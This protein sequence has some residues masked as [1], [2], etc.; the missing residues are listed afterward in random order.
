MVRGV[1]GVLVGVAVVLNSAAADAGVVAVSGISAAAIVLAHGDAAAA[2][3]VGFAAAAVVG[4]AAATAVVGFAAAAGTYNHAAAFVV[5][6][7]LGGHNT[8]ANR[9]ILLI[10]SFVQGW[11]C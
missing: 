6:T 7:V 4:F 5:V 3:V 8:A 2:V 9:S 1:A 10:E 11:I